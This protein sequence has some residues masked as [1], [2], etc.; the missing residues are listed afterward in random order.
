[1]P[2]TKKWALFLLPISN[3]FGTQPESSDFLKITLSSTAISFLSLLSKDPYPNPKKIVNPN[4]KKMNLDQQHCFRQMEVN[5]SGPGAESFL[6]LSIF[7][8]IKLVVI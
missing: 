7:L 4:P 1:M 8:I 2:L 3:N 6:K 5:V